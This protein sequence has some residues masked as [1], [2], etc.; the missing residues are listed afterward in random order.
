MRILVKSNERL[1]AEYNMKEVEKITHE[2]AWEVMSPCVL[3]DEGLKPEESVLSI[4]LKNGSEPTFSSE[5][6]IEFLEG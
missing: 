2:M 5:C 6:Q 1:I 3:E 4:H